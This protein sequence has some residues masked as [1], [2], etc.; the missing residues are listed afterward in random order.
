MVS[1]SRSY[2]FRSSIARPAHPLSTLR[3]LPCGRIR[4]TRGQCG[5]LLLH[6]VTPFIHNFLPAFTD[7]RDRRYLAVRGSFILIE[8]GYFPCVALVDDAAFEL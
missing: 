1:A 3:L 4:M 8:A 5:S 2:A 6:C 7:A